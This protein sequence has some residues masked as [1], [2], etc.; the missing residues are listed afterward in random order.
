MRGD[1]GEEEEEAFFFPSFTCFVV[2]GRSR[3]VSTPLEGRGTIKSCTS[4]I[5]LKFKQEI[6]IFD[7]IFYFYCI[8]AKAG[9]HTINVKKKM[10]FL[11]LSLSPP[12]LT[13]PTR[14]HF[15]LPP[16]HLLPH[17]LF[18]YFFYKITPSTPSY[19]LPPSP[20]RHLHISS[21]KPRLLIQPAIRTTDNFIEAHGVP[22]G[23]IPSDLEDYENMPGTEVWCQMENAVSE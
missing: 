22:H 7:K 6:V 21:S 3:E 19:P 10:H 12:S 17:P 20:T 2:P 4:Y 1:E 13:A 8:N 14:K 16:P 23:D 9:R 15:P 5:L 11:A 18:L